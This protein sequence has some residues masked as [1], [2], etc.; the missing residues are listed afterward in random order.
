MS[1]HIEIKHKIKEINQR[2]IFDDM[3]NKSMLNDKEKQLLILYYVNGKS[4]N[5]IADEMGYSLASAKKIHKKAL[6]KIES[7]L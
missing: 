7:L 3:L 4:L 2:S 5:Y 6:Q 1:K